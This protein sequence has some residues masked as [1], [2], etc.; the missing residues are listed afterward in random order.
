MKP[1]IITIARQ[2]GSGGKTVGKMLSEK[3]E[4]PYY[5]R[6][7]IS[8][9]SEQSGINPV[10]FCDEQ[11]KSGLKSRLGS[12]F[13]GG[14]PVTP[15]DSG[16]ISD[17]NIFKYQEQTIKALADKGACVMIGR[18]ADHIL[19]DRTDVIRVFVHATPE[20]CLQ[21][22]MKVDSLPER[23]VVK[24]IERIDRYRGAYYKYYTGKEW[25]D[26]R[27]FDITLNSSVLGFEGTVEAILAYMELR[28][29]IEEN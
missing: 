2:Y 12:R 25:N 10:L 1:F 20:F 14:N 21:E 16:F 22:A 13:K 15:E 5:E 8:L 18:C 29:K 3:L 6:E 17:D 24:K 23:E 4:I 11:L 28:T 27:N 9:A 19:R 7:I 26:A